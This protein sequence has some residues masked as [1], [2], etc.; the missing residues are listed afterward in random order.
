ML[1]YVHAI[2]MG[3]KNTTTRPKCK[4]PQIIYSSIITVAGIWGTPPPPGNFHKPPLSIKY[5]H[6]TYNAVFCPHGRVL[7]VNSRTK[8]PWLSC[9]SIVTNSQ[10]LFLNMFRNR[11]SYTRVRK[12]VG[13]YAIC[14]HFHVFLFMHIL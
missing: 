1:E 11:Y 8:V 2:S 9:G 7:T 14:N 5:S 13:H 4:F 6:H 10:P 12:Y 3:P